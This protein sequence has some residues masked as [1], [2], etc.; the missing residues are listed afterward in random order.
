MTAYVTGAPA[1]VLRGGGV[2]AAEA[3]AYR[4]E[5]IGGIGHD[6]VH[7]LTVARHLAHHIEAVALVNLDHNSLAARRLIFRCAA[8]RVSQ[9]RSVSAAPITRSRM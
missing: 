9:P 7:P 4:R 1:A 6:R 3:C 5:V 8:S 2:Q